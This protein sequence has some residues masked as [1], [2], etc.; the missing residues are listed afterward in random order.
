MTVNSAVAIR[1]LFISPGHNFF[2]RHGLPAGEHPATDVPAVRVRAGWGIEGDRFFG[3]RPDYHGQITFFSWEVF[4]AARAEFSVPALPADVFRR[5]VIVEGLHL[6]DLIGQRFTLGGIEFEGMGE[7]KPCHWMNAAV[8]P[9]AEVWLRGRGGLR[10]KVL[11][12][13]ELDVGATELCVEGVVGQVDFSVS[14]RG[15]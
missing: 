8:A 1:H 9:G 3:Y 15:A 12:D 5:N 14:L 2:G 6:P 4:V 10:A 7:A 11:A 13:G